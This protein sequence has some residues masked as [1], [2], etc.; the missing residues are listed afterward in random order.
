M[1]T[2]GKRAGGEG[3]GVNTLDGIF[4]G[5]RH[6][7]VLCGQLWCYSTIRRSHRHPMNMHAVGTEACGHRGRR[8][9]SKLAKRGNAEL[10]Q[11]AHGLWVGGKGGLGGQCG[12]RVVGQKLA[13]FCR[14]HDLGGTRGDHGGGDLIG[15]TG[16]GVDA[17][18]RH[19]V[20]K[21]LQRHIFTAVK[22]GGGL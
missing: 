12:D 20:Y 16:L 10:A 19:C 11:R 17:A 18:S 8:D 5:D 21:H 7:E 2:R 4:R 14:R 9:L 15:S 13:G 1:Q 3:G 22:L 6:G